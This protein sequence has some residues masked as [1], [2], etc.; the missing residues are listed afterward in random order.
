MKFPLMLYLISAVLFKSIECTRQEK[1]SAQLPG[2]DASKI[3]DTIEYAVL[4]FDERENYLLEKNLKPENILNSDIAEVEKL[5]YSA[6]SNYNLAKTKIYEKR[7]K[8]RGTRPASEIYDP[9]IK[10]LSKYRVQLI[11]AINTKGEKLVWVNC[12][13]HSFSAQNHW[14]QS[15]VAVNDGGNWFFNLKINLTRKKVYD[16]WV[17][18]VA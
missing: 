1:H 7:L 8:E 12:F 10:D 2:N 14:K 3:I 13:Y 5:L 17:N 15:V 9:R 4:K 11:A 18:G 6:V 16:F